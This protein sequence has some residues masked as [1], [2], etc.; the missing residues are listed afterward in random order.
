MRT[1]LHVIHSLAP[2]R[3]G[4]S[5]CAA[6]LARAL[7]R[8]GR[9]ATTLL[10]AEE[11]PLRTLR[12][13]IES[14][15]IVHIHGIWNWHSIA[16]GSIAARAG[17]PYIVSA[18][19]MLD[20]WALR[21]KRWKK[22]L[23]AALVERRNLNR[24][25]CLCALT[26]AEARD[27]RAFGLRPPAAVIPNGIEPVAATPDA[28]YQRHPELKGRALVLYL[29]RIHHKKGV[30]LLARAW[31]RIE[32]DFPEARLVIA[33]PDPDNSVP[34]L[35]RLAPAAVFT[36]MLDAELKWSALAAASLFVLPSH[37]EGFSVAVLEA[38]A[39]AL[40]VVI[41]RQ[42]HFPEVARRQC[43]VVIEPDET[44]LEAA[45]RAQLAAPPAARRQAGLRGRALV[46]T[47][48]TW[49]AIAQQTA[50]LLDHLTQN[51]GQHTQFPFFAEPQHA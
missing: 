47:R 35:K 44:Q 51:P 41:T 31:R 23:Y 29:G 17:V 32:P 18:H 6:A 49:A 4:P 16:A 27:Y 28:F 36:G 33:G 39:A 24:A 5:V 40:P 8:T 1:V 20:R 7:A 19:G 37:S 3:G 50:T 22:R 10:A 2:D 12:A 15:G 21:N 9:Y 45:L 48:Y 43:G 38:L 26:D 14:A 46:E 34:R 42:C 25:A 30:D 11:T 13:A